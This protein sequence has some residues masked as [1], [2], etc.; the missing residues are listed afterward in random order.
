MVVT[1][2]GVISEREITALLELGQRLGI[3]ECDREL[4]GS[5]CSSIRLNGILATNFIHTAA[6]HWNAAQKLEALKIFFLVA[7]A[8]ELGERQVELLAWLKKQFGLSDK[9]YQTAVDEVVE[10]GWDAIDWRLVD[11]TAAA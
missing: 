10:F 7:T 6:R 4:L 5:M 2:D 8:D 9:E 11:F 1:A 3:P